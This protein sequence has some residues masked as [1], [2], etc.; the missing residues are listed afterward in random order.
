MSDEASVVVVLATPLVT[1]NVAVVVTVPPLQLCPDGDPAANG[2][3]AC[4]V[5]V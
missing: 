3:V 1:T 5:S 4:S 2:A